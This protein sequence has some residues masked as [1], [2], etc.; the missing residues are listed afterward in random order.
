M[1]SM[2]ALF[3]A[4]ICLFLVGCQKSCCGK[5]QL[6][7]I[8]DQTAIKQACLNA[9]ADEQ[10]FSHFKT[11]PFFSLLYPPFSRE[12][13]LAVIEQAPHLLETV[14]HVDAVGGP[15][16]CDFAEQGPFSFNALRQLHVALQIKAHAPEH[17]VIIGA[18]DAGLCQM[19]Q[20]ITRCP[21]ITLVDLPE[22]LALARKVLE[23]QGVSGVVFLTPD[24]VPAR[25]ESDCVVSDYYFSEYAKKV[26]EQMITRILAHAHTGV[27]FCHLFPRHFG[28]TPLTPDEL[29]ERLMKRG[30]QLTMHVGQGERAQ[31]DFTWDK[32]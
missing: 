22:P 27:F 8:Y 4:C 14:R 13:G 5:R 30:L 19:V 18:G 20:E 32:R 31:Y 29:K 1:I 17:I 9:V 11:D 24:Q 6:C 25:L 3:I 7:A 21:R 12:E 10:A 26:Q 2:K 28:T 15:T 16:L 23:K